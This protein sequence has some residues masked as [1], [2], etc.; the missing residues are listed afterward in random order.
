MTSHDDHDDFDYDHD[1]D[2]DDFDDH[3]DNH[4]DANIGKENPVFL[5]T[6]NLDQDNHRDY[7]DDDH[8]DYNDDHDDYDDLKKG[9]RGSS[10]LQ[11]LFTR[12]QVPF[13]TC[14]TIRSVFRFSSF[15][16][17]SSNFPL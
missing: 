14:Q 1:D 8:E 6:T 17:G 10:C 11:P 9:G 16:C 15:T 2:D 12:V 5:I 7:D 13:R 3:D 4:S